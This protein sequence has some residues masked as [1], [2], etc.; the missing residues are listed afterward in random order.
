MCLLCVC[1]LCVCVFCVLCVYQWELGEWYRSKGV[2]RAGGLASLLLQKHP[3]LECDGVLLFLAPL[4][5][6]VGEYKVQG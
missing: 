1:V 2:A 3:K 5:A 4:E 6:G